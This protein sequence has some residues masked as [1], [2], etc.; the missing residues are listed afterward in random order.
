MP[1]EIRC[2]LFQ[3][4][5]A[6]EAV[7]LHVAPPGAHQGPK[8]GPEVRVAFAEVDEDGP[9]ATV[10]G[11]IGPQGTLVTRRLNEIE[12]RG[13]ILAWCTRHAVPLPRRGM[14]SVELIGERPALTIT[15]SAAVKDV[16]AEKGRVRYV[17][18]AL[19]GLRPTM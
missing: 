2:I 11:L 14:K 10:T 15:L 8:L 12:L 7:L 1:K 4:H 13:A 18:P 6:E 19:Q 5:E 16:Q 9:F 17:D 3:T